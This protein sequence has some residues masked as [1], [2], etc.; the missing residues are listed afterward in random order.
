MMEMNQRIIK[1]YF[2]T[3]IMM[4]SDDIDVKIKFK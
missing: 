1:R 2:D 3:L 4:E